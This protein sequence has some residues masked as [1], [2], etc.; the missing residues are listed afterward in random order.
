MLIQKMLSEI[1]R[2]FSANVLRILQLLKEPVV[3]LHLKTGLQYMQAFIYTV[4]PMYLARVPL[5]MNLGSTGFHMEYISPVGNLIT[6]LGSS[7]KVK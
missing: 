4:A 3:M 5:S 1:F 6:A 2:D 7:P